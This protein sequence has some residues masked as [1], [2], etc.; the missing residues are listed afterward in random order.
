MLGLR[1]SF[2]TL[3]PALL[4]VLK[5]LVKSLVL[6]LVSLF[7]VVVVEVAANRVS[8]SSTIF[9]LK[10]SC[11]RQCQLILTIKDVDVIDKTNNFFELSRPGG[12]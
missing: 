5:A 4:L 9:T 2:S 3:G 11:Y 8:N 1:S 10:Q 7:V 12:D 6:T